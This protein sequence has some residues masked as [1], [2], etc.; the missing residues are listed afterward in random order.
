MWPRYIYTILFFASLLKRLFEVHSFFSIEK[1]GSAK[2]YI[3]RICVEASSMCI[4]GPLKS[5]KFINTGFVLVC[6]LFSVMDR[7]LRI[8]LGS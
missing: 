4:L 3:V 7:K 6:T 5:C 8:Y 1:R 2:G